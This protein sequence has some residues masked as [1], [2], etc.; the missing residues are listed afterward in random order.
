MVWN[1]S[2]CRRGER[3]FVRLRSMSRIRYHLFRMSGW[4][5]L[6]ENSLMRYTGR[7]RAL[8]ARTPGLTFPLAIWVHISQ[9]SL[10]KEGRKA[11]GRWAPAFGVSIGEL[12]ESDRI[13]CHEMYH[14]LAEISREVSNLILFVIDAGMA[15]WRALAV[16]EYGSLGPWTAPWFTMTSYG[17]SQLTERGYQFFA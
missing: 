11:A 12:P 16:V 3:S 10:Y 9:P 4:Q 8:Q 5:T 13:K 7:Y 15:P 6:D 14:R 17:V 2:H 1:S